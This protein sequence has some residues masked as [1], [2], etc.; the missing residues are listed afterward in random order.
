M[1]AP[2]SVE[3]LRPVADKGSV[4]AFV[5]L[6]IGGITIK[7]TKIIRQDGQ[8]PWLGM[9]GIKL[10]HGWQNIVEL[11]KP[12]REAVTEVVLAAWEAHQRGGAP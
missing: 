7:G 2:I 5:D 1:S 12:L 8:R 11:S 10:D 6:R 9:P 4:K 3:A